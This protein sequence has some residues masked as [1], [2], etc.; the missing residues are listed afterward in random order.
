M[1]LVHVPVLLQS[2]VDALA[3]ADGEMYVDGTFG[4]GGY[5]AAVLDSADCTVYAI[6]RDPAALAA[7]RQVVARYAGRLVLLEGCFDDMV[8]LLRE[9]GIETVAGVV[10]DIGVSSMQ[11]DTPERGF[12]FQHDGPLD[13]RM[14]REGRS[15]ADVVNASDEDELADI[16]FTYGEEKRSRAV[17]RAIVR[18]RERAPI[19]RTMELA[20]I[21]SSVVRGRPGHHPATR[22]FQALRVYVN[23][24]LGQ[25]SRGLNAAEQ[26]LAPGGRLVV[27]SFHSLEDRLVKRFLAERAGKIAQGSRHLPPDPAAG[28]RAPTFRLLYR[29][30]VTPDEAECEVNPRARSAKL[31]AAVRTDAPAWREGAAA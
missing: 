1:T 17:A 11:L 12:S 10:L 13:M 15:A 22:T 18:A 14:S 19:E 4:A 20:A 16:L 23:D 7:G 21:V 8:A 2:V 5:S 27:V 30:A 24:E 28:R 6:D 25:L 3:P 26:V 9:R 31:R 29:S